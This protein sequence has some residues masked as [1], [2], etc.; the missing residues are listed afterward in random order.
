MISM[1]VVEPRRTQKNPTVSKKSRFSAVHKVLALFI[2]ALSAALYLQYAGSDSNVL[3]I[4]EPAVI[5]ETIDPVADEQNSQDKVLQVF[6]G[7]EFRLLF[8]NLLQPNLTRVETPPSITGNELADAR[9]RQLA[10]VRGY[11]LRSDPSVTLHAV[12][13][14]LLQEVVHEPWQEL[15]TAARVDGLSMSIVSA[16]RSVATQRGLFT[17]RLAAEGV[18]VAEVAAGNADEQ[19]TNVLITSSIPGFSKHHGGYTLDIKCAGYQFEDFVNSPCNDWLSANNY[20][21]AKTYGFIPSYPPD[22]D[23]Q[24]PDPEAWEYVYVGR[25]VLFL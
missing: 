14:F 23:L 10:D 11:K 6:S 18:S 8:D 22:A 24:G 21:K 5:T 13:G 4:D 1:R 17:S 12:D 15:K 16:Y 3:V 19:V 2:I 20:E 7:N 25:S 9:I